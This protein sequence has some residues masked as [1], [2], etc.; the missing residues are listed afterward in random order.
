MIANDSGR[1]SALPSPTNNA[2]TL[3]PMSL[4]CDPGI[5]YGIMDSEVPV[6]SQISSSLGLHEGTVVRPASIRAVRPVAE[7]DAAMLEGMLSNSGDCF[8]SIN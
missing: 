6:S 5:I 2:A 8:Y 4:S 1:G 7:L 3:C